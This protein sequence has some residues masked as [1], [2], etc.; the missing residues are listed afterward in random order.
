MKVSQVLQELKVVE[1]KTGVVE[2]LLDQ[3]FVNINADDNRE[4][5][6]LVDYD[7]YTS[8]LYIMFSDEN[9]GFEYNYYMPDKDEG[10]TKV[11]SCY[12]RGQYYWSPGVDFFHAIEFEFECKDNKWY[13]RSVLPYEDFDEIAKED[14]AIRKLDEDFHNLCESLKQSGL[15]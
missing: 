11:R 6:Y 3:P 5:D 4:I 13:L 10:D 9:T 7:Q 2:E 15:V 14:E 12:W 8:R 1:G